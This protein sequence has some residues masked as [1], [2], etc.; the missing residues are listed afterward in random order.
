MTE[1]SEKEKYRFTNFP[2]KCESFI[3]FFFFF[4]RILWEHFNVSNLGGAEGAM[5]GTIQ[6]FLHSFQGVMS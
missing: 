5:S 2:Q 3:R 6:P 1:I 4:L